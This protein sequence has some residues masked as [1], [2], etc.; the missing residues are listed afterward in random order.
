MSEN[1]ETPVTTET[2]TETPA[3]APEAAAAA[4][5]AEPKRQL[6]PGLFQG[7]TLGSTLEQDVVG[8]KISNLKKP[9]MDYE[10]TYQNSTRNQ[11]MTG[12]QIKEATA[13]KAPAPTEKKE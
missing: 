5:A 12:E 8:N 9:A 11:Q 2:K 10:K 13:P 4:P 3:A 7:F 6:A 1:K